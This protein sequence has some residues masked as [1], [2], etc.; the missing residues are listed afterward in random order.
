MR[1]RWDVFLCAGYIG[2]VH[3]ETASDTWSEAI[4][5]D[6]AAYLER[7]K[8]GEWSCARPPTMEDPHPLLWVMLSRNGEIVKMLYCDVCRCVVAPPFDGYAYDDYPEA[9][10]P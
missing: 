10:K 6:V 3:Y 1:E 7:R 4:Y 8:L 9:W 5:E 2:F